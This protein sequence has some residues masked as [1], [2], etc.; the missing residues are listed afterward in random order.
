MLGSFCT[1]AEAARAH[2]DASRKAGRRVVNFPRPGSDEVQAVKGEKEEVTLLRH[3]GE[4]APPRSGPP[5]P[6]S[7]YK[8]VFVYADA[9]TIAVYAARFK[10]GSVRQLLGR[11]CTA[12][13]AAR[14]YD[15]AA[16]KTGC[17]VVNF[18]RP[19]TDEVQAVKDEKSSITLRRHAAAQQEAGGVGAAGGI[20]SASTAL[21]ALKRRAAA[22][23]LS[24]PPRKRAIVRSSKSEAPAAEA[25]EAPAAP[26]PP[27]YTRHPPHR[28]GPAASP[29]AD[30]VPGLDAPASGIKTESPAAVKPEAPVAPRPACYTR[31]PPHHSE[32]ESSLP[33]GFVA[34]ASGIKTPAAVKPEAPVAPPHVPYTAST[35]R[36]LQAAFAAAQAAL[37]ASLPPDDGPGLD[38][39][40]AGIKTETPATVKAET[41]APPPASAAAAPPVKMEHDASASV[42]LCGANETPCEAQHTRMTA[43]ACR[44]DAFAAD[45]RPFKLSCAVPSGHTSVS[46]LPRQPRLH[47]APPGP[48]YAQPAARRAPRRI[49]ERRRG[50]ALNSKRRRCCIAAPR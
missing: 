48:L 50:A 6:A 46:A 15:D 35:G 4:C 32:R 14:A 29:P 27:R 25:P 30:D 34:P 10:D 45:T 16:R 26:P 1:A 36:P 23:P 19:G 43:T 41:P 5:P 2:D 37:A 9:R 47:L 28:I 17:R 12:E 7:D 8:G 24:E 20:A 13:Q 38:A 39:P 49:G 18:P 42:L 22:P 3:T 31:R 40:A 21:P 44:K 11:F 33:P